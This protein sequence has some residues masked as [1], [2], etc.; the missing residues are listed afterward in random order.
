M[1]KLA[2]IVIAAVA[3]FALARIVWR[4]VRAPRGQAGAC[5]GCPLASDCGSTHARTAEGGEPRPHESATS[6]CS[7]PT[8]HGTGRTHT[9][10]GGAA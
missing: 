5:C 8:Q 3:V 2:L 4:A 9:P 6:R 10:D 7:E 1:E